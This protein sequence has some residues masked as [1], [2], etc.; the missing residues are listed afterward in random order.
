[1]IFRERAQSML[2]ALT[3]WEALN[4]AVRLDTPETV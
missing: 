1:M 4:A 3:Q 2:T